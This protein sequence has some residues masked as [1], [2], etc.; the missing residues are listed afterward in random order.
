MHHEPYAGAP[1]RVIDFCALTRCETRAFE[2]FGSGCAPWGGEG[3]MP[4]FG[5]DP[6][7]PM[8]SVRVWTI[9]NKR[10]CGRPVPFG[11]GPTWAVY[12]RGGGSMEN[13][14]SDHTI[15]AGS[16][17]EPR[18]GF[19]LI[20]PRSWPS[21]THQQTHKKHRKHTRPN[22]KQGMYCGGAPCVWGKG[23]ATTHP[24]PR[25]V[26]H[27]YK[28]MKHESCDGPQEGPKSGH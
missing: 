24:F 5:L 27:N 26:C 14:G 12:V 21:H 25:K 3:N 7:R 20:P 28:N 16:K 8:F 9:Y 13:Q 10:P 18:H 17:C 2:A 1:R 22:T 4:F 15:Q 11:F 23:G 19:F 6:K